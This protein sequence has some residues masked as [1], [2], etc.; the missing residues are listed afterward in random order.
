MEVSLWKICYK[1]VSPA[2]APGGYVGCRQ[3][4]LLHLKPSEKLIFSVNRYILIHVPFVLAFSLWKF[5]LKPREE[6]L[7]LLHFIKMTVE[8]EK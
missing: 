7:L 1:A 2:S 4:H 6:E 3:C 8:T 5:D